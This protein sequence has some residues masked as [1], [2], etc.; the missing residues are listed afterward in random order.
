MNHP[1]VPLAIHARYVVDENHTRLVPVAGTTKAAVVERYH[2]FIPERRYLK[3]D[4]DPPAFLK[5]LI[6]SGRKL[7]NPFYYDS[8]TLKDEVDRTYVLLLTEMTSDP[9]IQILL[10]NFDQSITELGREVDK[11]N[12][13][14]LYLSKNWGFP[15]V[16]QQRHYSV[17]GNELLAHKYFSELTGNDRDVFQSIEFTDVPLKT[18][19]E[20]VPNSSL[21]LLDFERLDIHIGSQFAGAF[22]Y[23]HSMLLEDR[24]RRPYSLLAIKGRESS[25]LDAI[26]VPLEFEI[27]AGAPIW[28]KVG[29]GDSSA[30]VAI[31]E[32]AWLTDQL[33]IGVVE[34]D[35]LE[36]DWKMSPSLALTESLRS[37]YSDASQFSLY[38]GEHLI[39][40]GR[41][42]KRQE[43]VELR[44]LRGDFA[45]IRSA[46]R[47]RLSVDR[48]EDTGVV[49]LVATRTDQS[50][51]VAPIATY[52]INDVRAEVELDS[53][54]QR[55]KLRRPAQKAPAD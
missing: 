44:P 35:V 48:L 43:P 51:L 32:L 33:N 24:E 49:N 11:S 4:L 19:K 14:P 27:N 16:M 50:F 18:E 31:G 54:A 38:L 36:P 28:L 10:S 15:N 42:V 25:L 46:K 12:L 41:A 8:G 34:T 39:A 26:F 9:D 45:K 13:H 1:G 55:L 29:S 7:R 5:A 21:P 6:P 20:I 40:S 22:Q 47:S 53:L 3:F 23:D 30:R 2:S 52:R 37:S 17:H